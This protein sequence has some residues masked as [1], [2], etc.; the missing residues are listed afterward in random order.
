[1]IL[2]SRS[3]SLRQEDPPFQA[4]P[5]WLVSNK[6]ASKQAKR[7]SLCSPA[8]LRQASLGA[9]LR[10]FPSNEVAAG[11]S[12]GATMYPGTEPLPHLIACGK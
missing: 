12:N 2:G 7:G 9:Q 11:W 5:D 1:M 8:P 4:T 6:S 10:V 3:L